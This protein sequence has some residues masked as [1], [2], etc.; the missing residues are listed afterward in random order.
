MSLLFKVSSARNGDYFIRAKDPDLVTLTQKKEGQEEAVIETLD[1]DS[2]GIAL[3]IYLACFRSSRKNLERYGERAASVASRI[4]EKGIEVSIRPEDAPADM[5][6]DI[7]GHEMPTAAWKPGPAIAHDNVMQI[8]QG[9]LWGPRGHIC[10]GD[11]L[12]GLLVDFDVD[13]P[14][15]LKY[16][17]YKPIAA[18]AHNFWKKLAGVGMDETSIELLALPVHPEIIEELNCCLACSGRIGHFKGFL[19]DFQ[20]RHPE[21]T[22]KPYQL[23]EINE[24][25]P[26]NERPSP[27]PQ[28]SPEP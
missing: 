11:Q 9:D 16:G 19:A 27:S 14:M 17:E 8:R 22:V 6:F 1:R 15:L 23:M 12:F 7:D 5:A 18:Y 24:S 3:A 4:L 2:D 20:S 21:I 28:R 26:G 10:G 13:A 25:Q